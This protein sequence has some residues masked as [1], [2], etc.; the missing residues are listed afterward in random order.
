VNVLLV[1]DV[2]AQPAIV[3]DLALIKVEATPES[4]SHALELANVFRA[5]VIDVAHDSLTIEITGTEDKIDSLLEVLRPLGL[6]EVVRTGQV[7]MRR[8]TKAT[9]PASKEKAAA[10]IDDE[11]VSYSV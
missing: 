4:R 7:A 10:V 3:R 5:R 1:D 2:T 9:V 8:G 11:N 6:I